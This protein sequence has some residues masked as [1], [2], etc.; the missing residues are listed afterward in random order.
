MPTAGPIAFALSPILAAVFWNGDT[1][2]LGFIRKRSGLLQHETNPEAH[3]AA[4]FL[5]KSDLNT[6]LSLL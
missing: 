1:R 6:I 4:F 3:L 5:F 2:A